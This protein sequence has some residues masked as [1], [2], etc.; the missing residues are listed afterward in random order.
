MVLP[1]GLCLTDIWHVL[2][3]AQRRAWIRVVSAEARAVR[4]EAEARRA[5]Q[6]PVVALDDAVGAADAARR[7]GEKRA[8]VLV[9]HA[10]RNRHR[11]AA[12]LSPWRRPEDGTWT[13]QQMRDAREAR[14]RGSTD[15]DVLDAARAYDRIMRRRLRGVRTER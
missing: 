8:E 13:E 7:A 12:D 6:A 5:R 9:R 3:P 15:R 10:D 4:A 1:K 11:K 14:Y 2:N